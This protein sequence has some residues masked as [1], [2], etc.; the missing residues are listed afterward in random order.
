[1]FETRLKGDYS[2]DALLRKNL[3]GHPATFIR[4]EMFARAG[5]FDTALRYSMDY[6]LWLRLAR[7][8]PVVAVPA[9]LATFRVHDQSLSTREKLNAF[10]E[11][12]RIR[13]RF[14]AAHGLGGR[15][16]DMLGFWRDCLMARLG[17]NNLRK[18]LLR[19]AG[20]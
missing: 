16:G 1:M 6:D 4:R 18:R 5:E 15:Y 7:F 20:R 14:R 12:Y 11:S 8:S 10:T 17:L 19:K 13:Q 3:I 9:V 2:L